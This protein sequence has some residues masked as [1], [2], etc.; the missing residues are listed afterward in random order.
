M[1]DWRDA[2]RPDRQGVGLGQLGDGEAITVGFLE[3]GSLVETEH[4]EALQVGVS[5]LD[6][7]DGYEDMSGEQVRA[8]GEVEDAENAEYNL[9]SS[10]SRLLY[11]LAEIGDDLTGE[12]VEITAHGAS[13]SFD[14]TYAIE[15]VS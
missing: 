2:A 15:D 5:V 13:D 6:V 12:T 8:V 7:P 1:S 9:M 4:G 11:A 14:R 3:D 10:S